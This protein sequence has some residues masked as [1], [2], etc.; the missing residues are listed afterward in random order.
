[1][2]RIDST[3]QESKKR[4]RKQIGKKKK[5]FGESKS[6]KANRKELSLRQPPSCGTLAWAH[7]ELSSNSSNSLNLIVNM[8]INVISEISM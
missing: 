6:L 7:I 2:D 4:K 5:F 1:M 3:F 8:E